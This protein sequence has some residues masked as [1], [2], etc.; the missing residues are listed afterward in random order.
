MW[1]HFHTLPTWKLVWVSGCWA[2]NGTT[3]CQHLTNVTYCT[4]GYVSPQS[5]IETLHQLTPS[6]LWTHTEWHLDHLMQPV[7]GLCGCYELSLTSQVGAFS[8]QHGWVDMLLILVEISPWQ[9][10]KLWCLRLTKYAA[11]D[12][13][14][15]LKAPEKTS[16]DRVTVTMCK[17]NTALWCSQ[18][19]LLVCWHSSAAGSIQYIW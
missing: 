11:E 2:V 14:I 1:C 6:Q 3:V 17:V 19:H 5:I 4:T 13:V 18:I 12:H 9:L 15:W 7:C 10:S 16:V 8:L